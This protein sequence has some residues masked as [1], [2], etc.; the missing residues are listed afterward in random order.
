MIIPSDRDRKEITM[1]GGGGGSCS[2][3]GHGGGC[4][5]HGGGFSGSGCS[6]GG[7]SGSTP[8]PVNIFVWI[9]FLLA[10]LIAGIGFG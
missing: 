6:A 9:G 10:C 5:G 4:G 2:G 7:Y 8:V 3:G 1:H